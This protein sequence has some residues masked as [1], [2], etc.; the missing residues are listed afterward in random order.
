MQVCSNLS[1]NECAILIMDDLSTPRDF[2]FEQNVRSK[3]NKSMGRN[4]AYG[5]CRM[6]SKGVELIQLTD[7]MLGRY[8][9]T[10]N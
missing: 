2:I 4:A 7:I 5:V 9:M 10:I 6:Y 1:D 3:I 8:V